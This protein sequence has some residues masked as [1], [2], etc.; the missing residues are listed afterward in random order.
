MASLNDWAFESDTKEV[1]T[2]AFKIGDDAEEEV[3]LEDQI[4]IE[5][6]LSDTVEFIKATEVRVDDMFRIKE[7]IERT[8]GMCRA[9]AEEAALVLPDFNKNRPLNSYTIYPT[10]QHYK[11]A[12]EEIS[13]GIASA[14]AAAIAALIAL[15]IKIFDWVGSGGSSGGGGGR[16]R[17]SSKDDPKKAAKGAEERVERQSEE[18]GIILTDLASESIR[19]I[20]RLIK[21][22]MNSGIVAVIDD[23][24]YRFSSKNTKELEVILDSVRASK[25][26]KF[27]LSNGD[28][29][30]LGYMIL[31]QLDGGDDT[32]TK[33][34]KDRFEAVVRRL[35]DVDI[36][37]AL[38]STKEV[39]KDRVNNGVSKGLTID[40]I[41]DEITEAY[42]NFELIYNTF[43]FTEDLGRLKDTD[44]L[45]KEMVET[46]K[47]KINLDYI[48]KR[49]DEF[50]NLLKTSHERIKD[51]ELIII[52]NAEVLLE[53]L[54]EASKDL[55]EFVDA[56]R[57]LQE[58]EKVTTAVDRAISVLRLIITKSENYNKT[59]LTLLTSTERWLAAAFDCMSLIKD[60]AE[61]VMKVMRKYKNNNANLTDYDDKLEELSNV[62]KEL[63]K[64]IEDRGSNVLK[65]RF[66]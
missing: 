62:V 16:S 57:K 53:A 36:K 65:L 49:Q 55:E 19:D 26:V 7:H 20:G 3:S 1:N 54:K 30:D 59:Y 47:R 18:L 48:F 41:A 11:V 17:G 13:L 12:I 2:E 42:S 50:F 4:Q 52:D 34:I 22:I 6:D 56:K 31:D 10:G 29:G 24:D 58:D 9:V 39:I 45:S 33:F 40:D 35:T 8:G 63:N 37:V 51:T 15:T 5:K 44:K 46:R 38:N 27:I 25:E 64:S 28:L 61:V 14:I 23:K 21:E 32:V 60:T 66:R 43:D